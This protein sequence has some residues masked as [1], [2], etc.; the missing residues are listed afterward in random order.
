MAVRGVEGFSPAMWCWTVTETDWSPPMFWTPPIYT[1]L[2]HSDPWHALLAFLEENPPLQDSVGSVQTRPA[3]EVCTKCVSG[4]D[5][6]IYVWCLRNIF[7]LLDPCTA[8]Q[9]FADTYLDRAACVYTSTLAVEATV[10]TGSM[11]LDLQVLNDTW[12]MFL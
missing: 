8:Q 1:S 12:N 2:E 4:G 3:L 9:T 5:G 6:V 11:W 10:Y 7:F